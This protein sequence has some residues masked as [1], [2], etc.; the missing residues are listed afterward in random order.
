MKRLSLCILLGLTLLLSGCAGV[1]MLG[2]LG[3]MGGFGVAANDGKKT[4]CKNLEAEG[5]AKG[6]SNDQIG[7]NLGMAGCYK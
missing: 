7:R 6:L 4:R 2:N 3:I 5:I 1:G